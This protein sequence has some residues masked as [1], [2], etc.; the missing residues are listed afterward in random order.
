MK[1]VMII[2]SI[3]VTIACFFF[4][5]LGLMNLQPTILS[6]LMFFVSLL[7]TIWMMTSKK[8]IQKNITRQEDVR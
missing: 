4:Y 6:G 2:V 8:H 1:R 7:M 3:M 5:L